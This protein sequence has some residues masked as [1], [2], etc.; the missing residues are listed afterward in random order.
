MIGRLSLGR[1]VRD[2][3]ANRM[4]LKPARRLDAAYNVFL[5]VLATALGL[6]GGLYSAF[7]MVDGEYPF[8]QRRAQAWT[9]W[10]Q[11]GSPDI[12]PYARAILARNGDIPLGIGE[13]LA[14]HADRDDAGRLLDRNC[15][16]FIEGETPPARYWT[17]SVYDAFGWHDSDPT[18]RSHTT[19]SRILRAEDGGME[20]VIAREPQPG[21]WLVSPLTR[22]FQIVLRLYD[23]PVGGTLSWVPE[24]GMPQ[25][26]R[27]ECR[28]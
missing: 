18:A 13:G 8:G 7:W 2:R 25:I 19:S 16:Y 24:G 1:I 21:N 9:A 17:L 27:G 10:P 4:P 23:T 12:D 6:A 15:T 11:L 20:I 3:Q 22:P 5:I 28:S 26:L 14:F